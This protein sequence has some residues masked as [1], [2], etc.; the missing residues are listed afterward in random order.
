M[1]KSTYGTGCFALMNIGSDFELS[2][3]KLLTTVAY[4]LA[5]EVTYALEGSIFI[6]GAA[7]QWLRDQLQIID[8]AAES[9]GIATSVDDNGGVYMVPAF[10]GLG[11]PFWDPDARAAIMGMTRNTTRAHIVRAALEAQ[12]YQTRDLTTAMEKDAGQ[13]LSEIRVDGGMVANN[14]MCQF[15]SDITNVDVKRPPI[16]ETTA[17]GAAYLAG[18]GAG[19]YGSLLDISSR[20]QAEQ[21]FTPNCAPDNRK[22]LYEGWQKAVSGVLQ[23]G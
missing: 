16:I 17:L 18:M 9:E 15:L 7:V 2:E 14:W 12:A 21:T 22:S 23:M 20:W 11:A 19:F 6:A 5:G 8:H 4:R 13:P 1:I 3:N 10:T